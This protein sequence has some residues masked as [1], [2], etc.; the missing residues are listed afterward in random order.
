MTFIIYCHTNLVN[1]KRYVGQTMRTMESR[2]TAHV[3]SAWRGGPCRVFH[4][5]IRKYGADAFDHE[6]L[7]VVTTQEGADRAEI[8]WIDRLGCRVP[9]GYNVCIGGD[10]LS[11]S[12]TP[13]ELR[14]KS[15][16]GA[17]AQT[18]EQRREKAL[19][20]A[21]A[22]TPEQR[23]AKSAKRWKGTT[24]EQ[25]KSVRD[26]FKSVPREVYAAAGRKGGAVAGQLR[27]AKMTPEQL[28][29]NDRVPSSR[30]EAAKLRW[31]CKT[32]EHRAEILRR[33]RAGR[34]TR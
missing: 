33:M 14:A 9:R 16:K 34:C 6:I 31:A 11:A 23:S 30:S 26:A 29:K 2:W 7:D 13:E 10:R 3:S 21:A 8:L 19:K 24:P 15:L 25:R 28:E 17:A 12:L 5:A 1:G 32:P 18:A 22:Q 20:A 4:A 27:R